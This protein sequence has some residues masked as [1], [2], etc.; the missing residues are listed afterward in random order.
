M[1]ADRDI[2]FSDR[3]LTGASISHTGTYWQ[4]NLKDLMLARGLNKPE[5]TVSE[6]L[7]VNAPAYQD[8]DEGANEHTVITVY[9]CVVTVTEGTS[10]QPKH[11]FT[12]DYVYKL[13]E[14][15]R[16]KVAKKAYDTLK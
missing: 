9:T 12:T 16:E 6:H 2:V 11:M 1:S 14:N 7:S 3:S 5:Y 13:Q 15:A 8:S 10:T 4:D